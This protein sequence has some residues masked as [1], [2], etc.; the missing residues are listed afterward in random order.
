MNPR[1]ANSGDSNIGA[2]IIKA[3]VFSNKKPRFRFA[4]LSGFGEINSLGESF[5]HDTN[6]KS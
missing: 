2:L 3:F 1:I 4:A 5:L 6:F